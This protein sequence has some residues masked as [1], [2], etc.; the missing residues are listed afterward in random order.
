MRLQAGPKDTA[1]L[2]TFIL[3]VLYMGMI[4]LE[5]ILLYRILGVEREIE[6]DFSTALMDTIIINVISLV[7]IIVLFGR[8]LAAMDVSGTQIYYFRT[9]M[10][11]W[12]QEI[13]KICL[14]SIASDAIIL[15]VW[16]H[17]RYPKLHPLETALKG[18]MIN[19]PAFVLSGMLWAFLAIL[20]EFLKFLRMA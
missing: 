19:I 7:L 17:Y 13:L 15:A 16:Y 5:A 8:G 6:L 2:S 14:F 10:I 18:A 9:M 12:P 3:L 11:T 1:E 4:F 20:M